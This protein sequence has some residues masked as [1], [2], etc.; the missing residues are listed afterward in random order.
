MIFLQPKRLIVFARWAAVCYVCFAV[1]LLL[2]PHL[3]LG[4]VVPGLL[5]TLIILTALL[6]GL[7][8]SL[9]LAFICALS[10]RHFLPDGHFFF[11][12][13]LAPFMALFTYPPLGLSRQTINLFQVFMVTLYVEI[14]NA[15]I[16]C[17]SLGITHLMN[18]YQILILQPLLN[19]LL[20]IPLSWCLHTIFNVK[21]SA[22]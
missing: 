6:F 18:N 17:M 22:L 12:W 19:L 14:I 11:S 8:T 2:M 5:L 10:L 15:F 9:P 13:L 4:G 1:Q 21:A 16:F 3:T 20:A 7:E